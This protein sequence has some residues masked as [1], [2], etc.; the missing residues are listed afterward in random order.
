MSGTYRRRP[1]RPEGRFRAIRLT[2]EI[3]ED[4]DRWP[5]WMHAAER[6]VEI[7]RFDHPA[8]PRLAVSNLGGCKIAYPGMWVI[9]LA[10]GQLDAENDAQFWRLY[11]EDA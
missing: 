11:E 10:P 1:V 3:V 6:P 8:V 5:E 7:L 9:E 2:R 4:R